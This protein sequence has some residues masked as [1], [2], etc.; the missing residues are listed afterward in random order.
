MTIKRLGLDIDGTVTSPKTFLP[1]LNSSF[2]KQ[3]SLDDLTEYNLANI[4]GIHKDEFFK[5]LKANEQNIYANAMIADEAH[6]TLEAWEENYD[7]F[8]IS[9]RGNHLL[10]TT[11]NWFNA[12]SIPYHHIELIGKHDKI[13]SIKKNHVDVFFED[14]HD[15]ACAIAEECQIP[16]ILFNTPYNQGNVPANVSRLETW[17]QARYWLQHYNKN[18]RA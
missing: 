6:P 17:S 1:Y 3:L 7:L 16:V 4:L 18:G 14:K 8:Y 10:E 12:N 15:N 5:W 11:T 9:A 2:N 13:D